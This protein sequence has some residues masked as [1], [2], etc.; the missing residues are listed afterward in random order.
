MCIRD[1]AYVV[2]GGA[3]APSGLI[4]GIVAAFWALLLG[5]RLRSKLRITGEAPFLLDFELGALLAVGLD[6][7]LLRFDGTLSG[8]FSP[9]TYVLVALVASFGR[10]VAGL[11]V[12]HPT[13]EPPLAWLALLHVSRPH[14]RTGAG[15]ALWAEAARLAGEAGATSL[16]VSATSTGSAV[17]FY[18]AQGCRLADPVHPELFALEPVDVHLVRRLR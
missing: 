14:R 11:A 18:L 5:K 15:T 2:A 13:F 12:V 10:P 17:G 7:A 16:Y 9:A 3:A 1:S 4:P 8:R 6:A